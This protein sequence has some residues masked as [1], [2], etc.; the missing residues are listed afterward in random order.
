MNVWSFTFEKIPT[1]LEEFKA[2]KEA[3]L[4]TPQETA[5]LF[6]I[7]MMA[8]KNNEA[9]GFEL[10]DFLNGP[11]DLTPYD[12]QFLKDRLRGK[13]YVVN[14]FFEG[15]L[16]TNNYEPTLPYTIKVMDNQYSYAQ[17]GYAKLFIKSSGADSPRPITL[18]LKQSTNQWFYVSQLLL[19]GIRLPVSLD[20]WA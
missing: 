13:A 1:S 19:S 17:S 18:R 5:A 7:A 4:Q 11:A 9:L 3:Q 6:L 20:E 10:L 15:A 8:Y 2:L 14:S 16:P 12:K